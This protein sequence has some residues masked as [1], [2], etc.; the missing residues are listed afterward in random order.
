LAG[1]KGYIIAVYSLDDRLHD[2]VLISV[3]G[4]EYWL[5]NKDI[6]AVK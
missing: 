6:K 3:H 1:H 5:N 2:N 4:V